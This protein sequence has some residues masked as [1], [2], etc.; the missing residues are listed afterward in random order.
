[1]TRSHI[2]ASFSIVMLA[3]SIGLAQTRTD[4]SRDT[5]FSHYTSFMWIKQPNAVNPLNN[6]RIVQGVSSALERKGL[7]LVT[8][9]GDLGIAAHAATQEEQTLHTFY[10]GFG[11]GWNWRDSFGSATTTASTY[12]VGTLV[13]DIFDSRTKQAI[14][15]GTAM[16]T[17]SDK[18]SRVAD[19]IDKAIVRMFKDFPPPTS[20]RSR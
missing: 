19:A 13:V 20:A 18:P 5:D 12:T 1:M 7:K 9:G 16:K 8:S 10:D 6:Q 15:R 2:G 17:L 3:A 14:W 4:Y 11:G